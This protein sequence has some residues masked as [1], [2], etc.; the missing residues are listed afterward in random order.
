MDENFLYGSRARLNAGECTRVENRRRLGARAASVSPT[1]RDV[2][3]VETFLSRQE[4][5]SNRV[6]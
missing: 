2:T 6:P 4:R 1:T 5:V 3:S